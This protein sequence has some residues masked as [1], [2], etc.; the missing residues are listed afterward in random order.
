[1][2]SKTA[3]SQ[4]DAEAFREQYAQH[5]D[6]LV[7]KLLTM[8]RSREVAEDIAATAFATAL[9]KLDTFRGESS[10]ITWVYAIAMN[11]IKSWARQ[12]RLLPLIPIEDSGP[13]ELVE[14]DLLEQ[15]HDRAQCVHRIRQVLRSVPAVYRRILIDHFIDGRSIRKIARL[16]N[17]PQGTVLS[18]IFKGK[19]FLRAAWA[20]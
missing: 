3:G 10:L 4:M 12:K 13:N 8:T 16:H 15:V 5:K 11:E 20:A 6:R 1:M 14:P 2:Q 7:Y 19:Q 18:R 9:D 17:I